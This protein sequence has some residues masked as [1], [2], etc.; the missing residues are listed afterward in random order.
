[1]PVNIW[2]P[3][4]L[5]KLLDQALA[6]RFTAKKF[7]TLLS[8]IFDNNI[9]SNNSLEWGKGIFNRLYLYC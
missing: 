1:M 2:K 5:C 3:V 4:L 6:F 7:L 8:A 9:E